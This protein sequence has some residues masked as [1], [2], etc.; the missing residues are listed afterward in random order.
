MT[1]TC[2]IIKAAIEAA[3]DFYALGEVQKEN[4]ESLMQAVEEAGYCVMCGHLVHELCNNANCQEPH[5]D[6]RA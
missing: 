5:P 1:K 3:R 6:P 4:A 2:D